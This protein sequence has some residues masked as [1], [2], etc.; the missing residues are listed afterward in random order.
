MIRLDLMLKGA[1]NSGEISHKR[2]LDRIK[3]HKQF[4]KQCKK[5][6]SYEKRRNTFCSSKCAIN[7]HNPTYNFNKKVYIKCV[8][9]KITFRKKRNKK[10]CS[11][12]CHQTHRWSLKTKDVENGLVSNR[13]RLRKYL[14]EKFGYY[15]FVCKLTKWMNKQISLEVDHID[16]N[17]ENNYPKNLRLIC[18]NCHSQTP[19]YKAKNKGNGRKSRR[20]S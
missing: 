20:K 13:P 18:P 1:I 7:D 9:C 16:G 3:N 17:H 8:T 11:M 6:I 10:Y 15:C 12:G 4:C 2:K 19:T 14:V 5:S